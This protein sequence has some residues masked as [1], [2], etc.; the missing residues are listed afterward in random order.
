MFHQFLGVS[1]GVVDELSFGMTIYNFSVNDKMGRSS[2]FGNAILN[3][4]FLRD[5]IQISRDR[6][7]LSHSHTRHH[8]SLMRHST[9]TKVMAMRESFIFHFNLLLSFLFGPYCL[10]LIVKFKL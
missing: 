4:E 1:F 8:Y 3:H 6:F 2:E 7:T 5:L 9:R 10:D